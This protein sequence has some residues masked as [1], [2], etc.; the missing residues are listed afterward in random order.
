MDVLKLSTALASV[1]QQLQRH[2]GELSN[3]VWW[4]SLKGDVDQIVILSKKVEYMQLD[5]NALRDAVFSKA[6]VGG[7]QDTQAQQTYSS[8][9]SSSSSNYAQIPTRAWEQTGQSIAQLGADVEGVRLLVR[10]IEAHQCVELSV[11]SQLRELQRFTRSLQHLLDVR[12]PEDAIT[13]LASLLQ[14]TF[15]EAYTVVADNARQASQE[16]R[17]IDGSIMGRI[18][19]IARVIAQQNYEENAALTHYV[20]QAPLDATIEGITDRVDL[21]FE[22]ITD[23]TLL[24]NKRG[25][26]ESSEFVRNFIIDKVFKRHRELWG[27][28]MRFTLWAREEERLQRV[29]LAT[30]FVFFADRINTRQSMRCAFFDWA[31]EARRETQF[32]LF[33]PRLTAIVRFWKGRVQPEMA[34][35]IRRWRINAVLSR[36]GPAGGATLTAP[37]GGGGGGGTSAAEGEPSLYDITQVA[38]RKARDLPG[39]PTGLVA[40]I[41]VLGDAFTTVSLTL[42]STIANPDPDPEPRP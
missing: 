20:E 35:Y 29:G 37:S 18:P 40:R 39:D 21:L 32:L 6:L 28:W 30:Q 10:R 1:Q 27:R 31:K 33:T 17:D 14:H 34:K 16:V 24:Y 15:V 8:P 3:P 7:S 42:T 13:N 23:L 25:I 36:R 38:C 2:E 26:Q 22:K 11:F 5:I 41:G 12:A 19:D 4:A 9:S